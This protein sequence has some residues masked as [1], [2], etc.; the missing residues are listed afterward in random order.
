MDG[1][2]LGEAIKADPAIA[3][4]RLVMLTSLGNQL[5]SEAMKKA[6]IEA[7]VLKP[8]KQSRLFNRIAEVMAGHRPLSRK[9]T[10]TATLTMKAAIAAPANPARKPVR[11]LLAEDNVINQK[12]AVGLLNNIG[13][14]A[15]VAGNGLEVLAALD[16]RPYEVILMDCQMPELDGYET[17]QR[18]R[19]R[20]DCKSIRI[21][22]MTANAMRGESE[23]CLEA[24]MDDYLSK[25]VRLE[26]LRE[27]L[28]RWMP[29]EKA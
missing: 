21:I 15:D 8:V 7:C 6:G 17:T 13:F 9:K 26:N 4:V 12:V 23:K 1:L 2:M 24:G 3:A 28:L 25:P 11:V 16:L 14:P 22:A 27:M 5:D 29:A 20:P 19:Q 10:Q 18:I